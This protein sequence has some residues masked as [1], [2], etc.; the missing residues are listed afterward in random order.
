[1]Y[2]ENSTKTRREDMSTTYQR[3]TSESIKL[4]MKQVS[5]TLYEVL[6]DHNKL[7]VY[8]INSNVTTKITQGSDKAY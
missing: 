8:K 4:Y 3:L 6:R 2:N 1:M 5:Y 7:K